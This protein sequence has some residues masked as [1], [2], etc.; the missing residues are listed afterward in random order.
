MVPEF[1]VGGVD[2]ESCNPLDNVKINPAISTFYGV[3]DYT[4]NC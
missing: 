4:G 1:A 2:V 3:N